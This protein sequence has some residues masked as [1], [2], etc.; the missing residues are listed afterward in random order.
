MTTLGRLSSRARRPANHSLAKPSAFFERSARWT[1]RL[2]LICS[3]TFAKGT[4]RSHSRAQL[5]G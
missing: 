3:A 2:M 4:P 5:G 1:S